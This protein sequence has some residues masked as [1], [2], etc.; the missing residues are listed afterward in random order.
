MMKYK[1]HFSGY[2]KIVI[3]MKNI[4][5]DTSYFV[6]QYLQSQ[7]LTLRF[8]FF[9]TSIGIILTSTIVKRPKQ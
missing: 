8:E 1:L 4:Y 3:Y 7:N 5:Q 6:K 9:F 2:K